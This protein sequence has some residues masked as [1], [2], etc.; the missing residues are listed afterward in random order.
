[1]SDRNPNE[2][3][4]NRRDGPRLPPSAPGLPQP[5]TWALRV[6]EATEIAPRVRRLS[7]TG[8]DLARFGYVAGQDLMF[9]IPTAAEPVRRRYTIRRFDRAR[10]VVDVDFVIHG[11]GPAAR[12][13]AGAEPG[14]EI[15]AVGPRGKVV[16]E[17]E[18]DWHLFAGDESAIPA[19]FAMVEAL[20][21]G[22]P[23]LAFLEVD[24]PLDE[25]PT[26]AVV[27]DLRLRWL[28]RGDAEPGTTTLL[29]DA[30]AV[31]ELPPGAGYA[32]LNGELQTVK[33]LKATLAARGFAPDRMSA[34]GYWS[35]G[36]PNATHGEPAADA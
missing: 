12:W 32:Y 16:L 31:A 20:D 6:V 25:Q 22:V 36:R 10:V 14:A 30:L 15:E 17:P 28:H 19:T 21:A 27:A 1:M 9:L 3:G 18:V 35:V 5:E 33:A 34:K 4:A 13:A 8:P 23:A 24:G 29:H 26:G 7:F 2:P 11:D